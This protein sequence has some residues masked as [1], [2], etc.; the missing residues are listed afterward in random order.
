MLGNFNFEKLIKVGPKEFTEK[1]SP[2]YEAIGEVKKKVGN[3][4]VIGFT[5][6]PWTLLVYMLNRQSPK[7]NFNINKIITDQPETNNLLKKLE[8]CVITHITKQIEAGANII[9]L[10]DSWAGLLP[11][12]KL[13]K[14]CYEPTLKIL[15]SIKKFKV[16][17][18]C[19]PKGIGKNYKDFCSTVK[20]DCIN[21]DY[22]V[23][24]KWAKEN[25]KEIPIQGGLD[26]KILLKKNETIKIEVENYL[27]IFSNYPYVFNLGHG[28]LPETKPETIK[29]VTSLVQKKNDRKSS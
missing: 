28:V 14:Y 22:E 21:I 11:S 8:E 9:Q 2:V 24:P 10:F 29:Y 3:K 4:N 27:N 12:N 7:K 6:A 23:D 1:M 18:I 15:N 17:I 5:G 13:K 20:P 25:L 16:P 19:F 26:P